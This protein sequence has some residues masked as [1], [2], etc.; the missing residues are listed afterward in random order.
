MATTGGRTADH[1]AGSSQ[2][3]SC[4]CRPLL[5]IAHLRNHVA[6]VAF[7]SRA[8][9]LIPGKRGTDHTFIDEL[10][11]S[12]LGHCLFLFPRAI[13]PGTGGPSI[14]AQGAPGNSA[15]GTLRLLLG[16]SFT[17]GGVSGVVIQHAA[18]LQCSNNFT[19]ARSAFVNC[20]H[21]IHPPADCHP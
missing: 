19:Y 11:P 10:F 9:L 2:V 7:D 18:S 21:W 8:L 6:W 12:W 4:V 3:R 13:S 15:E 14:S 20:H 16:I 5:L 1:N 17:A